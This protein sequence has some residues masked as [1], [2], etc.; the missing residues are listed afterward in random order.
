MRLVFLGP[1]GAGKGTQAARLAAGQGVPHIS[2]GDI[3]RRSIAL[4]TPT[5][6]EAKEY[7]DSGALVPFDLILRLVRD[8]LQEDD[9]ASGWI[10]DGFPRNLEQEH[11]FDDL[12]QE[13]QL[14]L[15]RVV[16]IHVADEE[17][18]KRLSG[19]RVCKECG[20]TFHVSFSPPRRDGVCDQCDGE[21]DSRNDD[22]EAAIRKRLDVF[23]AETQPLVDHYQSRD[24]LLTI[25]GG[26][27][28]DQVAEDLERGLGKR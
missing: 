17:L 6:I 14:T 9:T 4:A 20:E 18:V 11:A 24:L 15:S 21:L 23:R 5:G 12:L 7:V 10:L 13:L 3:L 2:T 8:R 16:Y 26:A 28:M 27:A 25:D 1:P 19:R 22:V